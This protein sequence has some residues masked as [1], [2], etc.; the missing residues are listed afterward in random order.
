MHSVASLATSRCRIRVKGTKMEKKL[1]DV[2][3]D[4]VSFFGKALK[5][6]LSRALLL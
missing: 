4:R 2:G 6:F 5:I 3:S 1:T